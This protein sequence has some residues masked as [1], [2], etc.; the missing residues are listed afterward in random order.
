MSTT[1]RAND[2]GDKFDADKPMMD[3]LPWRAILGV[4]RVLTYGA[5][6]YGAHNW[7]KG[8]ALSRLFAAAMRHLALFWLRQENDDESK[9]PT[10]DHAICDLLMLREMLTLHPEK[11]DRA[12]IPPSEGGVVILDPNRMVTVLTVDPPWRSKME[13]APE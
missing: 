8:I 3:L 7:E 9:L 4:A 10:L 12:E 1:Q 2:A 11:D 5:K 13:G 6:K